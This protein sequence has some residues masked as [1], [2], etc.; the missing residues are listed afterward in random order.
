ML[1]GCF[2]SEIY[3]YIVGFEYN[4]VEYILMLL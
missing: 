3:L 2:S 4:Y 1:L